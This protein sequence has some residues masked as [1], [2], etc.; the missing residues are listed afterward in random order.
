MLFTG[1]DLGHH[2]KRTFIARRGNGVKNDMVDAAPSPESVVRAAVAAFARRG[3]SGAKLEAL[4]KQTGMTKRMIHYHFGGKRGL[5]LAALRHASGLIKPPA[6][7]SNR[8][9][10]APVEGMRRYVDALYHAFL[11]NPDAVRL[12]L[13]ENLDPVAT[14]EDTAVLVEANEVLLH[15]ERLLLAGQDAGAFRPGI[16]AVDL[17]TLIASLCFFRVGNGLTALSVSN[18]DLESRRNIDGMRRMVI[19]TVLTFLTSNI[20]HS[21]YESYLESSPAAVEDPADIYSD[22]GGIV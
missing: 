14:E 12:V 22:D 11:D 1:A 21:G 17:L 2:M 5:Y 7:I 20:P 15:V 9:Y 10:A 6:D 3:Y 16:S 18:V 13:R 19:D 8:S 4:A